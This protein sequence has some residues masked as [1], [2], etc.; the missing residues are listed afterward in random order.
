MPEERRLESLPSHD[1]ETGGRLGKSGEVGAL[2]GPANKS[3][4]AFVPDERKGAQGTSSEIGIGV[5]ADASAPG[6]SYAPS[7]LG[8]RQPQ[9][10]WREHAFSR[11][12]EKMFGS[13]VK[14]DLDVPKTIDAV[15]GSFKLHYTRCRSRVRRISWCG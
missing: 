7:P 4:I 8:Q 14:K 11:D 9:T 5:S 12:E 13:N 10:T 15:K 2:P 1:D 3:D 6:S